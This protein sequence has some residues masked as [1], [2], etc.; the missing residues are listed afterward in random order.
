MLRNQISSF[1]PELNGDD[2]KAIDQVLLVELVVDDE[3]QKMI[4]SPIEIPEANFR[5]KFVKLRKGVVKSI[6]KRSERFIDLDDIKVGTTVFFNNVDGDILKH[7]EKDI[8]YKL[9][10]ACD[11]LAFIN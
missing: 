1:C 4:D 5:K 6:G 3:L 11:I 7:P 9:V 2:W 8:F 10:E